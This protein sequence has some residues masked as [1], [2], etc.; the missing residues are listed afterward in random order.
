M[1]GELF[2]EGKV[3]YFGKPAGE[4]PADDMR[5]WD[6]RRQGENYTYNVHATEQL[7]NLADTKGIT[8][9]QLSAADLARIA[10]ILPHGLAGSRLPAAVLSSFT[11]D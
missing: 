2:T 1:V 3:K 11:T 10:E 6:E 8:T 4:Y 7:K 5:S 9:A